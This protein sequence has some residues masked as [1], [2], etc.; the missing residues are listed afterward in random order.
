[1]AVTAKV[2]PDAVAVVSPPTKSTLYTSQ[3]KRMPAYN[4]ST[5]STEN[6]LLKPKPITTWVGTAFIAQMSDRFTTT[7][8]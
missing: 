4:S 5:A 6:R 7:A 8:L 3:A 2:K 1:M